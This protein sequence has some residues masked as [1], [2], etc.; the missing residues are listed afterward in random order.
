MSNP[1]SGAV[2]SAM[3]ARA[4]AANVAQVKALTALAKAELPGKQ[5]E[6]ELYKSKF[7]PALK[8]VQIVSPTISHLTGSFSKIRG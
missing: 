8:A 7:G 5:V 1:A 2:S 4:L 6:A 3:E